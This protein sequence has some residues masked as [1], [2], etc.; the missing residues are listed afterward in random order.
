M[1]LRDYIILGAYSLAV[2]LWGLMW[3]EVK[4]LRGEIVKLEK[5][6]ARQ[7][8]LDAGQDHEAR[9]TRLER[10]TFPMHTAGPL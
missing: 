6:L 9:I 8:G 7:G 4:A 10:Y 5:E 3:R 2:G 1:D